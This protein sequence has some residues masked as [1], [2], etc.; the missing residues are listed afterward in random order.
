MLK[1]SAKNLIVIILTVAFIGL[2]FWFNS[3]DK[4]IF[5]EQLGSAQNS[6]EKAKVLNVIDENIERDETVSDLLLGTQELEIELLSGEFKG[7]VHVVQNYLSTLYN[8]VA[9]PGSNIIVSVDTIDSVVSSISVY[10]HY[11]APIL[12]ILILLFLITMCIVGGKKG[13]KSVGGIFYT[14]ASIIFL[15]IPMLYRGYSPIISSV[16]IVVF[17]TCITLY[18]LNGWSAKTISAIIGTTIGVIIAGV[19]SHLSGKLAQVTGYNTYEAETLI[20][21][22]RETNMQISGLLFAGIL[23]AS[24]GA[25]MDIA[26]SIASSIK[27]VHAT[28][29]NISKKELFLSGMN[30]GRDMMGTSANTLILA[31]TGSSLNSLLVIYSLNISYHQIINMDMITIEII[32]GISGSIAII[33]TIPI[34][35]FVSSRLIPIIDK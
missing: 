19:L 30:V 14:V 10:S 24:L 29:P 16:L 2:L 35:A 26:M 21:V 34:V 25:I 9:Q 28:N 31:F 27:E 17:T 11:R 5:N 33:L 22:A 23:I 8:V 20:L 7:E 6:Y 18:L 3:G 4:I 15:F 13:L 32:Q 1:L 12:Y